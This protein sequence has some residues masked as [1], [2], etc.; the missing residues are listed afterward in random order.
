MLCGAYQ[1]SPLLIG[2]RLGTAQ[3][4]GIQQGDCS[5]A[6]GLKLHG[7]INRLAIFVC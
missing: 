5:H 3:W 6:K 2:R 4:R 1:A 7:C